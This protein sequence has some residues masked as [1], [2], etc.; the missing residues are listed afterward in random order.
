[1]SGKRCRFCNCILAERHWK[2]QIC[3]DCIQNIVRPVKNWYIGLLYGIIILTIFILMIAG[4]KE[5]AVIAG[6]TSLRISSILLSIGVFCVLASIIPLFFGWLRTICRVDED[7]PLFS[8]HGT[9]L[10][11]CGV[12]LLL[13]GAT[14]LFFHGEIAD[15]ITHNR[16]NI[17]IEQTEN[18]SIDILQKE[19]RESRNLSERKIYL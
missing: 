9:R 5:I 13:T 19:I 10:L 18:V 17:P 2:T 11:I 16:S 14:L 15:Y 4:L 12:A 6:L 7:F 3:D 1:M 8:R